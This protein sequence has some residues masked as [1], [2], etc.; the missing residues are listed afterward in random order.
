MT[1]K[2]MKKKARQVFLE[3]K[4]EY[5]KKYTNEKDPVLKELFKRH[6]DNFIKYK[7]IQSQNIDME[8]FISE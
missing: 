7:N 4:Y 5:Y 8:D 1:D 6:Y 2:Q 3:I